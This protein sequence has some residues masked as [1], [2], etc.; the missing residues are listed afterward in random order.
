MI[1]IRDPGDWER[2]MNGFL[3]NHRVIDIRREFIAEGLNSVW[4]I[5]VTYQETAPAF[6]SQGREKTGRVDYREVLSE[7]DFTVFAR[8]RA[9]RKSIAERDGVPPYA[10]FSNEQLAEMVRRRVQS[11]SAMQEIAGVGEAKAKKYAAEFLR[12]IGF[13]QPL[14]GPLPAAAGG[15]SEPS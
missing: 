4:A 10:V 3:A 6:T 15:G 11:A 7:A 2:E 8:L 13:L 12:E 5:C 9:L 14:N 1:P